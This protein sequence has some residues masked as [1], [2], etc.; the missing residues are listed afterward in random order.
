[1]AKKAKKTE[2]ENPSIAE[3][4]GYTRRDF[5]RWGKQGGRPTKYVSDAEKQRDYRRRKATKKL[6]ATTGILSQ[7]TG[8]I[9]KYRNAAERQK[10]YR[11]RK[12]LKE[13]QLF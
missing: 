1:M 9:S 13:G 3:V 6:L 2:K 10:A 5:K 7:K 12:K 11:A 8:R 4:W